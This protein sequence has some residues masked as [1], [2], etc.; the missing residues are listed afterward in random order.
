M[1]SLVNI[2]DIFNLHL[3]SS[4]RKSQGMNKHDKDLL[5]HILDSQRSNMYQYLRSI[6]NS[7]G[8]SIKDQA[9]GLLSHV[10]IKS[11]LGLTAQYKLD[12]HILQQQLKVTKQL[13]LLLHFLTF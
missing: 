7:G 4:L 1:P 8:I 2:I 5:K 3:H 11:P 13:I 12:A 10:M 9:G 6:T